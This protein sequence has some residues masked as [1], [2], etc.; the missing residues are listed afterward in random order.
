MEDFSLHILDLAENGIGA[1]ASLIKINVTE[2]TIEDKVIIEIEDNGKG[3]SPEFLN[4]ALDP[5][6]TTRTTRRVGLGLSLF[7][8]SVQEA[9]GEMLLTSQL[10]VGTKL[11]ASMKHSH[12]DRK[13]MGDLAGTILC[14]IEGNSDVDFVFGY[15][16]N[17]RTY[18]LDTREIRAELDCI[19]LN[20]PCVVQLI[21]ENLVTGIKETKQ[22]L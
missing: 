2:D 7:Q 9:D 5:F 12:I 6:V 8:Q 3:M 16:V 13:P 11:V 1:G 22:T 19:S 17:E 10:G 18:S 14:L 15:K 4:K 20:H 21:R